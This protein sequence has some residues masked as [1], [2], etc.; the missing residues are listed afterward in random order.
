M[1]ILSA[2][3]LLLWAVSYGRC[4]S[5]QCGTHDHAGEKACL[6]GGCHWEQSESPDP[7]PLSTCGVCEFIKTGSPPPSAPYLLDAPVFFCLPVPDTEWLTVK[8]ELRADEA[9]RV[10]V[11][12]TG[13]PE[14][15]RMCEWM[16]RTAAPVRGPDAQA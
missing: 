1:R 11:P 5:E 6:H 13:P 7:E 16:A 12:D 3:V 15:L 9:T 8:M 2:I 14:V 10:L 4:L